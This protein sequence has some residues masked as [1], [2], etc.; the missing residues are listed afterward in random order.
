MEP[1]KAILGIWQSF[2]RGWGYYTFGY[3]TENKCPKTEPI[4]LG[5]SN[6]QPPKYPLG[7]PYSLYSPHPQCHVSMFRALVP[8][9][10]YT[11]CCVCVGICSAGILR[12]VLVRGTRKEQKGGKWVGKRRGLSGVVGETVRGPF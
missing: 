6:T 8:C 3:S 1:K 4:L 12:V 11:R 7:C 2:L 10:L 5:L 9:K